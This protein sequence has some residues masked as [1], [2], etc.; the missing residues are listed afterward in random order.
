VS[1]S[2]VQADISV[3]D[4][5]ALRRHFGDVYE[6]AHIGLTWYAWPHDGHLTRAITALAGEGLRARVI[7][8]LGR[9]RPRVP[10]ARAAS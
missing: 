10:A 2:N 9:P 3:W 4:L 1:S 7:E 5:A 8:D 6:F